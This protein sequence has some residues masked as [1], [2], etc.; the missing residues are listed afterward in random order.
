MADNDLSDNNK[1]VKCK[2]ICSEDYFKCDS[3]LNRIHRKCANLTPSEVKCMPLQKRVLLLICEECKMYIA[4]MPHMIKLMEE[5]KRDIDAIRND[6]R[7]PLPEKTYANVLQNGPNLKGKFKSSL[8]TIVIKPKVTQNT[9]K[10]KREIQNS[11][12]P[13]NLN[14]GIKN[15]RETKQ[16]SIVITCGTEQDMKLF[17][18]E[19]EKKLN[20]NYKIELSKKILPRIKIAGYSGDE[21]IENLEE[22]I[23][24][25]NKWIDAADHLRITYIR[26][27]KNKPNSTI[28]AEC[29]GSLFNK[30]LSYGKVYIGW[31][32]LPVYE[33]LTVSRCYKCQ[34][35]R[36]KSS[37]CN[38]AEVCGNCAGNHSTLGCERQIKKCINCKIANGSYNLQLNMDHSAIDPECPSLKYQLG[39]LQSKIDYNS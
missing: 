29:S 1:C 20:E 31:E 21:S 23:R 5:M 25:Q 4:R 24:K 36:H 39:L 9:Q 6:M 34:G 2:Q 14:L 30:M 8:P 15:L 38:R 19:A 27:I 33:D 37:N 10:S 18:E 11:I 7:A 35:F 17:K 26:R 3:C 13:A 28:N 12:N 32:S 22:K 16:G